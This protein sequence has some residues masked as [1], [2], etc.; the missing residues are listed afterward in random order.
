MQKS[1]LEVEHPCLWPHLQV[2]HSPW[3]PPGPKSPQSSAP[4]GT[5]AQ[6]AESLLASLPSDRFIGRSCRLLA[7]S[8]IC[9][10]CSPNPRVKLFCCPGPH[11][12]RVRTVKSQGR[13]SP[14]GKCS[15]QEV[16][17]LARGGGGGSLLHGYLD[18]PTHQSLIYLGVPCHAFLLPAVAFHPASPDGTRS[19]ESIAPELGKIKPEARLRWTGR[20]SQ[21]FVSPLGGSSWFLSAGI[22]F[23]L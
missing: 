13:K 18:L 10:R 20:R 22:R 23:T 7:S 5:L 16:L 2:S 21:S 14:L 3:P 11:G 6:K 15:V 8:V 19:T 4:G 1:E 17:L 12:T 9:S